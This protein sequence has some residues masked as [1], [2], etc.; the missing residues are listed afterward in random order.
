MC[1]RMPIRRA[2]RA[3]ASNTE[4]SPPGHQI[5]VVRRRRAAGQRQLAQRH[6]GGGL[7]V[8]GR[9]PGPH[10]VERPEPAE[11]A[12]VERPAPGHPLVE[13][14]V[15]V[16]QAG[17]DDVAVAADHL[18]A[19]FGRYR[20]DRDDAP[21]GEGD[22]TGPPSAAQ[23]GARHCDSALPVSVGRGSSTRSS[24]RRLAILAI[25]TSAVA[26]SATGE[27]FSRALPD[28]QDRLL[29]VLPHGD[30]QREAELLPVRL[31][32]VVEALVL[33]AVEA[34]ETGERLV[35]RPTVLA[36]APRR[37]HAAELRVGPDEL[38]LA[39]RR[40]ASNNTSWNALRSVVDVLER[41]GLVRLLGDPRR[42]LEHAAELCDELLSVHLV[43]LV[44][45]QH[46]VLA[47]GSAPPSVTRLF[48]AAPDVEHQV[49]QDRGHAAHRDAAG[50][51][52]LHAVG[53]SS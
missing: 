12:A 44:D 46:L 37:R 35:D 34:V 1:A 45:G 32:E 20:A 3:M 24:S 19:G 16:D 47:A 36:G 5:V 26:C 21:V 31:G 17:G 25:S 51:D 33:V 39:A 4:S 28:S 29:G 13:V 8:L 50:D 40:S 27:L 43:D 22:I 15:G 42:P 11:Q 18:V 41:S 52:G 30:D 9:H 14:V 7:D 38:E 10:R 6:R 53:N 48:V 49:E 2:E 23:D